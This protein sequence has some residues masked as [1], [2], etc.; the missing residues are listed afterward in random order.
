[1]S[2]W[3]TATGESQ[4]NV[5]SN[6]APEN[7]QWEP[8]IET[9][10]HA[11]V[12]F[13]DG[14]G[15]YVDHSGQKYQADQGVTTDEGILA[16]A[17]DEGGGLIHGRAVMAS[18]QV[19]LPGGMPTSAAVAADLGFL[20]RNPDG[21]FSDMPEETTTGGGN[22]D[23]DSAAEESYAVPQFS[24]GNEGEAAMDKIVGH[25]EAGNAIKTMDEILNL[26]S[27]SENTLARMA[28]EAGMEPDE[29]AA[30]INTAHQGFYDAAASHLASRG[31]DTGE[32][33]EA[34]IGANPRV[35]E[36][37]GASARSLVMNNDTSGL[38][39]VADAFLE[40]A[41]KFMT[42][43]VEAAL[44]DAGFKYRTDSNGGLIVITET[45]VEVPF[46]VAVRQKI[47]R[48]V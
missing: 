45:G 26:G 13:R 40:Q 12:I 32:A 43:E 44:D 48:F 11:E 19:T 4:P 16:S 42:A 28:S 7:T 27:V 24:I 2:G 20:Q 1:M 5:Q 9:G 46:Q 39:E 25:V 41:D 34:F 33:F 21:T 22:D 15:F 36:A 38:D 6:L 10:M 30:T 17:R 18:D 35:F 47:V 23:N 3:I 14:Q 29:M 31:V 37:L 8:K